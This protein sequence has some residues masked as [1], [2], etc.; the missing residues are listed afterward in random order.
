VLL[1][2]F[3]IQQLFRTYF[4]ECLGWVESPRYLFAPKTVS[5]PQPSACV[6]DDNIVQA[7]G[8]GNSARSYFDQT[9]F[10]NTTRYEDYLKVIGDGRTATGL[11]H[12][13]TDSEVKR[14]HLMF[15]AKRGYVETTFP[16]PLTDRER[17]E[18]EHINT[19]LEEQ[20]LVQQ[21]EDRIELTALGA[22][23]VEYIYKQYDQ[24]F[25]Q[26]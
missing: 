10:L 26:N 19:H 25:R 18:L 6:W 17:D 15:G 20:K 4:A 12:R 14:R 22:L 2:K 24:S 1:E 21:H 11:F 7:V 13:L 23:L 3:R 8:F 9:N 5:P 16:I